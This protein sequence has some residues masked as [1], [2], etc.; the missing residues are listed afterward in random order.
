VCLKSIAIGYIETPNH[1]VFFHCFNVFGL[2]WVGN[3]VAA[4]SQMVLS[5]TFATWYWTQNK[6]H[7]PS[8]TLF[9]M[10]ETTAKNHLG[11]LVFGSLILA[12]CQA[13]N[14]LLKVIR[15]TLECRCNP[16][17]C[18]CCGWYQF[19]FGK[20]EKIVK[21]I[22]RNAYIMCSVHGTTFVQSAKNAFNLLMRNIVKVLIIN[23]VTDII[24]VFGQIFTISFSLLITFAYCNI[25]QVI[26]PDL[27]T[28]LLVVLVASIFISFFCFMVLKTAIDTIFLCVLE[29]YERNDGSD[30]RP[31]F[32]SFQLKH[33]F[34]D[35]NY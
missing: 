9:R 4:F 22:N 29:D 14:M 34:L 26:E 16:C 17:C 25:V 3:F 13:I 32:M 10:F 1:I 21:Y 12:I 7:V 23:K 2:F 19:L 11:T 35:Q 27:Q 33:L 24:L 15:K 6:M 18:C 30:Q 31:Y 8:C 20:L 5:G 28:I